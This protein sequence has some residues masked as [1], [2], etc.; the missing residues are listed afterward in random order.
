MDFFFFMDRP[1][2]FTCDEEGSFAL[3]TFRS[4]LPSIL[5]RVMDDW[6]G[7]KDAETSLENLKALREELVN[8]GETRLL[9]RL[10]GTVAV[11]KKWSSLPFL[12]VE[13]YFYEALL[14]AFGFHNEASPMYGLDCFAMQKR[15]ARLACLSAMESLLKRK[16]QET[17]R[18]ALL[19]SYFGNKTD[20]S[21]HSLSEAKVHHS[22]PEDLILVNDLDA[23]V[24]H[25]HSL[26]QDARIDIIVDNYCFELFCDLLLVKHLLTGRHCGSVHIHCKARPIF[27]SD[28]TRSNVEELLE[29]VCLREDPRIVVHDDVYWNSAWEWFEGMPDTLC[30]EFRASSLT[31]VKGD[32][33]YRKLVGERHYAMDTPFAKLVDY[34]P[35]PVVGAL[36]GL[37]CELVVGVPLGVCEAHR[38]LN[39]NWNV[40]GS[41]G[42]IQFANRSQ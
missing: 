9:T 6:K 24:S 33:N 41:R 39:R 5:D 34:F 25:I 20:L 22:G 26:P 1:A 32:A 4:R 2:S 27:V 40:D 30:N 38:N 13:I 7:C 28:A 19:S 23:L 8:D 10:E 15:E 37:K 12:H 36:R 31:L 29:Y 18:G 11:G 42:V 3:L 21:L 16:E 17:T 14:E 35:C